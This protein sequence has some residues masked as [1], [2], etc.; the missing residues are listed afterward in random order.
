MTAGN[1]KQ[2]NLQKYSSQRFFFKEYNYFRRLYTSLW[3]E[4][5]EEA[6]EDVNKGMH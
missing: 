4:L 5:Q 6:I 1:G 2:F 3:T